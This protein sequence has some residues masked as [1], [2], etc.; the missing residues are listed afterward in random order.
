MGGVAIQESAQNRQLG[1]IGGVWMN[2]DGPQT[3]FVQNRRPQLHRDPLDAA[4][5][6]WH[7]SQAVGQNGEPVIAQ[8]EQR[9]GVEAVPRCD[10]KFRIKA[11]LPE[12]VQPA[13]NASVLEIKARTSKL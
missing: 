2:A 4:A 6:K 9:V 5:Q 11:M 8:C 1:V 13:R 12:K 3:S 10:K 7:T